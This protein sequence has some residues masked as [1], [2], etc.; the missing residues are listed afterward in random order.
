MNT[1]LD[2]INAVDEKFSSEDKWTKGVYARNADG[3]KVIETYPG[4][5]C[6]CLDGCVIS[7]TAELQYPAASITS[8]LG[9]DVLSYFQKKI[10]KKFSMS[11]IH[12]WNDAPERTFQ[13]IK[14][15][16]TECKK[17]LSV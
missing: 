14:N 12:L 4:A 15:L 6:W 11:L 5:V 8:K 7:L 16:L 3:N 17:E 13:D 2:V 1:I 9:S 10:Y